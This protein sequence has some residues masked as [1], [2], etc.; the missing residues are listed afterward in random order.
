MLQLGEDGVEFG[1]GRGPSG[2]VEVVE[3]LLVVAGDGCAFLTFH[4]GEGFGVPEEEVVGD[5]ADGVVGG[6]G[7]FGAEFGFGDPAGLLGSEV[8]DGDVDGDEPLFFGVSGAELGEEGGAEGG[9]RC[10]GFRGLSES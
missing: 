2:G 6:C 4:V 9:G 1:C 10:G 7:I 8:G 5:H 3:G